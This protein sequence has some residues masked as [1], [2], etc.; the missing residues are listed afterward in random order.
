MRETTLLI[1]FLS[2]PLA[3]TIFYFLSFDGLTRPAHLVSATFIWAVLWWVTQPVPWMITALLPL[4]IFP[5]FGVMNIT[6]TASLY[7]Q[8]LLFW[9]IGLSLFGYAVQKHGLAKRFA[10]TLLSMKGVAHSTHTLLFFYMLATAVISMFVSDAAVVAI[11]MPVGL[12]LLSYFRSRAGTGGCR[13]LGNF[14]ALGTLYASVAGGVATIAGTPPSPAVIAVLEKLTGETIGWFRWMKV[15]IPLFL[16]LLVMTY[17]MLRYFFPPEFTA[18]PGGG[19]EF[20]RGEA[21]SLGKMNRGEKNV[22][23]IFI[24]MI[25][26]LTVPSIAPFV[27]GDQHPI[28]IGLIQALPIY[29]VPPVVLLLLF[30][31]PTDVKKGEF[32]LMWRDVAEHAP[33]NIA[34]LSTGAVAMVEALSKF[35][36]ADFMKSNFAA[37]SISADTLPFLAALFGAVM[38]EFTTAT[39]TVTILG[40]VLIPAASQIGF[41]PASIAMLLSNVAM[42]MIFPWSGPLCA[43]AFASGEIKLNDMIRIGLVAHAAFAVTA[44]LMHLAFASVF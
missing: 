15:G 24:A 14:I 11:M 2:G 5:V 40:N 12:S 43:L 9:V 28:T 3:F 44:A 34:F 23:A 4:I 6:A 39:A 8:P 33:W 31:L 1:K 27:F 36:F 41:N 30:A 21:K 42:G 19:Q 29:T 25:I 38:T 10:I 20:L 22:L 17:Y 35:G 37:V 16:V 18:I 7:G 32:T 26:M 13:N